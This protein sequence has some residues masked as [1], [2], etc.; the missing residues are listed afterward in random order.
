MHA[1][2][3]SREAVLDGRVDSV[4]FRRG[5]FFGADPAGKPFVVGAGVTEEGEDART[6]CGGNRRVDEDEVE[7]GLERGANVAGLREEDGGGGAR[8]VET[9]DARTGVHV[10][11]EGE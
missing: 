2:A 9:E 8:T 7:A 6:G 3:L 5:L 4:D 1:S 11:G 10:D